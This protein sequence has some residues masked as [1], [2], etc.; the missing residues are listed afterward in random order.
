[1][2]NGQQG[3][4]C[5]NDNSVLPGSGQQPRLRL[6]LPKLHGLRGLEDHADRRNQGACRHGRR[7]RLGYL[8]LVQWEITPFLTQALVLLPGNHTATMWLTWSQWT[9]TTAKSLSP[10]TTSIIEQATR[11]GVTE[12]TTNEP[13]RN[14]TLNTLSWAPRRAIKT[15]SNTPTTSAKPAAPVSGPFPPKYTWTWS[16]VASGGYK[17][18][19]K[20]TIG[21]PEHVDKCP[22]TLQGFGSSPSAVTSALRSACSGFNA[23]TDAVIPTAIMMRNNTAKFSADVYMVTFAD[24]NNLSSVQVAGTYKSGVTCHTVSTAQ[25]AS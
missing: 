8:V 22:S 23:R 10:N 4:A 20:L 7:Q 6:C 19:G 3:T 16:T 15:T 17:F 25:S 18:S 14:L 13:F 21:T 11:N 1:M 12:P 5:P 9:S 24:P 2:S